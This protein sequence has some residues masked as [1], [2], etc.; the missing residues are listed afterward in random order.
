MAKAQQSW[1][2]V[3]L[4]GEDCWC[5]KVKSGD[6]ADVV[7]KY[8]VVSVAV[9]DDGDGHAVLKFNYEVLYHA[10]LP[11]EKFAKCEAFEGLCGDIL[12]DLIMSHEEKE[13]EQAE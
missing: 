10:E 4:D 9:P 3:E 11:E 12:F 1:Q 2:L 7:Y 5:V 13:A 6:Y 8:T